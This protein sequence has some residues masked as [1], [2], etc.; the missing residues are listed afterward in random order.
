MNAPASLPRRA[1]LP[2]PACGGPMTRHAEK[3]VAPTT[4]EEF[5]AIDVVLL[6]L[7]EEHHLCPA[8]SRIECLRVAL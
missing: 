5:A 4:S 7:L 6:G 8:C 3:L 2:C 1:P